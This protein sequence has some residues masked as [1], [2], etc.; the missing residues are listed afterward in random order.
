MG[1]GS[2]GEGS[3]GLGFIGGTSPGP[4]LD[5]TGFLGLS[6]PF[7]ATSS[8]TTSAC[9]RPR[10]REGRKLCRERER[11]KSHSAGSFERSGIRFR[12][13]REPMRARLGDLYQCADKDCGFEVLIVRDSGKPVQQGDRKS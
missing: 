5:G 13:R 1:F 8:W 6:G 3:S 7:M 9:E 10:L 2:A 11:N 4:G 12:C